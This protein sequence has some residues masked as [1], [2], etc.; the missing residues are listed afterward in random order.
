MEGLII[1]GV[2]L[3]VIAFFVAFF[4]VWY[5]IEEGDRFVLL[6]VFVITLVLALLAWASIA[7]AQTVERNNHGTNNEV[8]LYVT[9]GEVTNCVELVRD[10][11][12]PGSWTCAQEVDYTP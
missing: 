7:H 5:A 3:I 1:I 4:G 6:G 12:F 11:A 8:N 10:P 9:S 2:L